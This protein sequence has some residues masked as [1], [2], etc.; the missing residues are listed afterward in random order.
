MVALL[1]FTRVTLEMAHFDILAEFFR[2]N[3]SR[4]MSSID[5]QWPETPSV[6]SKWHTLTDWQNSLKTC[7]RFFV[8][9]AEEICSHLCEKASKATFFRPKSSKIIVRKEK[10]RRKGKSEEKGRERKKKLVEEIC[11]IT[12]SRLNCQRLQYEIHFILCSCKIEISER[13]K[14]SRKHRYSSFEY[15][16]MEPLEKKHLGTRREENRQVGL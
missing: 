15:C 14:I 6:I 4:E 11:K 1:G 12:Q 10:E 8:N 13:K 3:R 16:E 5:A 2:N 9:Q 7:S